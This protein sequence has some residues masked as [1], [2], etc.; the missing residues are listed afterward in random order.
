MT[1][2]VI[3][4]FDSLLG[5]KRS[6]LHVHIVTLDYDWLKD[7]RKFSKPKTSHKKMTKSLC[8]NFEK[9]FLE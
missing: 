8:G 4:L 9:S 7:N 3:D 2:T 6:K 1:G 5:G